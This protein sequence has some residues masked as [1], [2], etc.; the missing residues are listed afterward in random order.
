[1]YFRKAFFPALL[2]ALIT[3]LFARIAAQNQAQAEGAVIVPGTPPISKDIYATP[4]TLPLIPQSPQ[5][6]PGNVWLR[7]SE[8]GLDIWG[9]VEADANGFRWPRQKSEMLSSD[10]IEIWLAASPD[11]LMPAIAWGN[12][13]GVTKLDSVKDCNSETDMRGDDV[14]GKKNCERWYAEQ[15]QYRQ[16]LGRLFTRQWLIAGGE[17]PIQ[18]V[19]FEDFATT[20]YAGLNANL[21]HRNLPEVLRA[22]EEDGLVGEFTVDSRQETRHDAAGHPYPEGHQTGY[23]FH[24]FIPYAAFP[25][26]QQLKLSELYLMVDVFAA[27]PDGRAMGEYSSTSA[28]RVWGNPSTFNHVSLAQPRIFQVTPCGEDLDQDDLYGE[29]YRSWFFPTQPGKE[30]TLHSTFALINPAGGY[31]YEPGGVSPTVTA[32]TYFWKKLADGATVCGPHLMWRKGAT[33]Q[34]SKFEVEERYFEAKALPDGWSLIRSGPATWTHSPFGSGACGS[35]EVMGLSMYAVSPQGE[36]VQALDITEDLSGTGEQ[37]DA[38]DLAIAQ[39]WRRITLYREFEGNTNWTSTSYCLEGHIYTECGES[40]Q[41]KPPD[42]PNFKELRG[43][44]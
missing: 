42:P 38:A 25:P 37:P 35:C 6:H 36:I 31:M 26:T 28:A 11:V 39:D 34:R 43:G 4:P 7:S 21:F 33:V 29:N 23:R 13:F 18:A 10:H 17:N 14:A 40:K 8:E 27:A 3:S 15:V 19:I 1:M 22:K 32:A 20:A 30:A 12:Q 24:V 9:K 44:Y 16:Y 41:A 5:A 2:F